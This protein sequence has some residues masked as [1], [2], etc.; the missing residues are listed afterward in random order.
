MGSKPSKIQT[1]KEKQ[2]IRETEGWETACI[3]FAREG[4]GS[5]GTGGYRVSMGSCQKL[6]LID[7]IPAGYFV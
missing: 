3:G 4:F 5:G 2:N 7:P 1:N 6:S